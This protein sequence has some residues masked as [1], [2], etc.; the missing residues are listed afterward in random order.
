[1]TRLLVVRHG[2][3]TWNADGRWQGHADPPLSPLGH[4]QAAAAV[5]AAVELAVAV[6]WTSPLARAQHTAAIIAEQLRAPLHA[7][8]RLRERDVGEW[9][10]LT[11]AE[12]EVAWPG[13]LADRR[14]PPGF[15][16]DESLRARGLAALGAIADEAGEATV[17]VVSHGGIIRAL[18]RYL[19]GEALPL[20][21]LGGHVVLAR[22]GT[23]GV[24]LVL[25]EPVLLVGS[26]VDAT[27]PRRPSG[28]AEVNHLD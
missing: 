5:A 12:I 7:D 20:A 14:S 3:S 4:R 2:Q 18:E 25:G 11:R 9:T 13:Y 1:M 8:A 21:N 19:G 28:S 10:G 26:D 24:E 27:I 22:D 15:E 6:V 23:G 16:P 17:L